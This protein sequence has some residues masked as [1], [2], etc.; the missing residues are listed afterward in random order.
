MISHI[1]GNIIRCHLQYCGSYQ[2]VWRR[3]YRK[4]RIILG[5]SMRNSTL[6]RVFVAVV[7][8]YEALLNQTLVILKF[9]VK[10]IFQETETRV[11]QQILTIHPYQRAFFAMPKHI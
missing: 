6:T 9:S 7:L 1:S 11:V 2:T 5:H 3:T 10:A 4:G 8:T